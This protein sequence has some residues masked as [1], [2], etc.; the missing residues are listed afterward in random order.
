MMLFY[1][2]FNVNLQKTTTEFIAA[3]DLYWC[4][5]ADFHGHMQQN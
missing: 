2:I 3:Y 4:N 5:W 1:S